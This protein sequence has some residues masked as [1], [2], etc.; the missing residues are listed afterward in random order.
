VFLIVVANCPR[1]SSTTNATTQASGTTP[2]DSAHTSSYAYDAMS[3]MTSAT[4]PPDPGNNGGSAQT[5]FTYSAGGAFPF[6]V[7]HQKTITPSL[8][9]SSTAF[10]DGLGRTYQTQHPTSGG[11]ATVNTTFDGLDHVASVTPRLGFDVSVANEKPGGQAR[12]ARR[13]SSETL[14]PSAR[15]PVS[16]FARLL[17]LA[18]ASGVPVSARNGPLAGAGVNSNGMKRIH[19]RAPAAQPHHSVRR[20]R[21]PWRPA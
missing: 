6:S 19:G 4:A 20:G 2:G 12:N 1:S 16:V 3:R 18:L 11:T 9:N 10:F 5:V 17:V 14:W 21:Q 8:T 13:A 7:Q 15:R